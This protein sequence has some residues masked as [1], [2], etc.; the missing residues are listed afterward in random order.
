MLDRTR[1]EPYRRDLMPRYSFHRRWV[2]AVSCCLA[3]AMP[4]VAG[5][6]GTAASRTVPLNGSARAS[7]RGS[8]DAAT[9]NPGPRSGLTVPSASSSQAMS[10]AA[11]PT[12]P[13][14]GTQH[15]AAFDQCGDVHAM[16]VNVAVTSRLDASAQRG[17]YEVVHVTLVVRSGPAESYSPTDFRFVAKNGQAYAPAAAIATTGGAD[18]LTAGVLAGGRSIAGDV[19]FDVPPGGGTVTFTSELA[20]SHATW[21]APS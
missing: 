17:E 7:C 4:L 16:D 8:S 18:Q 15:L 20:G 3:A 11:L 19:V 5:C 2:V 12:L 9:N 1:R 13:S 6:A 10:G 14:V 21:P